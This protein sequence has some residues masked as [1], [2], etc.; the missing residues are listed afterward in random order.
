MT[1]STH[2]YGIHKLVNL[3][4]LVWR[5]HEDYYYGDSGE[6]L[7]EL[8]GLPKLSNLSLQVGWDFSEFLASTSLTALTVFCLDEPDDCTLTT[9][10][11][12]V[13]NLRRLDLECSDVFVDL[14]ALSTL[15]RLE[16]L[17]LNNSS[18]SLDANSLRGLTNLRVLHM[19]RADHDKP[20]V[21]LSP[22]RAAGV[23]INLDM[24]LE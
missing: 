19:A 6:D 21:D 5:G 22:L 16:V 18:G 4:S 7:K 23:Q 15:R 8:E 17:G 2:I 11:E 10:F 9:Q 20:G 1:D 13:P 24:G 14:S 12:G 3:T